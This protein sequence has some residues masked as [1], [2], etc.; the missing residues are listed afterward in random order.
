MNIYEDKDPD[1]SNEPPDADGDGVIDPHELYTHFDIDNNGVVTQDD[2][3][4]HVNWHCKHPEILAPFEEWADSQAKNAPCPET[5]IE[6]GDRLINDPVHA[7][8]IIKPVMDALG[9][10]CPGSTAKAL[11][12]VIITAQDH[13]IYDDTQ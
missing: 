1:I 4:A 9:T 2:Y 10:D 6:A 13:G 5:Y 8:E 3:T 12:D 11:A 7:L